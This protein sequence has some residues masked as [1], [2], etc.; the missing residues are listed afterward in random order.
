MKKLGENENRRRTDGINENQNDGNQANITNN[1]GN[2]ISRGGSNIAATTG[3][4]QNQVQI[5]I[6]REHVG[7]NG[8]QSNE[9]GMEMS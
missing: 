9:E 1:G 8:N 6:D 2:A 5:T 4:R 3:T 7:N